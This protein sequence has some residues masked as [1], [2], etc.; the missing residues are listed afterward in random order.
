MFGQSEDYQITVPP[1]YEDIEDEKFPP[2][3]PPISTFS[4]P[5]PGISKSTSASVEVEKEQRVGGL[6]LS[7]ME[8]EPTE[9]NK[10]QK[11]ELD[12][13]KLV[14]EEGISS[15][16]NK[17]ES[18][19]FK[20]EGYEAEDL[21]ALIQCIQCWANKLFPQLVFEDFVTNL[22]EMKELP[23]IQTCLR[24]L[25]Q[26]CPSTCAQVDNNEFVKSEEAGRKN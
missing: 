14:S 11:S 16:Q 7:Q 26:D 2:F 4:V 17:C 24:S 25:H 10:E 22:E 6:L 5:F 8:E 13:Q 23:E 3:P 21:Q 1:Y 20:G 9:N 19:S 12:V 15:L 18:I